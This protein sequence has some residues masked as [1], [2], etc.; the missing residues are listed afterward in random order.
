MN[1]II[2]IDDPASIDQIPVSGVSDTDTKQDDYV[3]KVITLGDSGVG[4]S[5][6]LTRYT[7]GVF[8]P[9]NV[10]NIGVQ[11][12]TKRLSI[13]GNQIKVALWDTAGQERYR[14]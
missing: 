2:K 7:A 1:S 8:I 13:G 3:V 5:S 11:V 9:D 4:K 14:A 6:I 10:S 12:E